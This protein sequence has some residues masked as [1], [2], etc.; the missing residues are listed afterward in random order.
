MRDQYRR[1]AFIVLLLGWAMYMAWRATTATWFVMTTSQGTVQLNVEQLAA[2]NVVPNPVGGQPATYSVFGTA[3][4]LGWLA[5]G[6]ILAGLAFVLRLSALAVL[7]IGASWMARTATIST[8]T[9]LIGVTGHGMFSLSGDHL[10][11]YLGWIWAVML[12]E[13]VLL[14]QL[15][16]ARYCEKK[17]ALSRGDTS[18][19]GVLDTIHTIQAGALNRFSR[20]QQAPRQ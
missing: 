9:M 17:A 15:T 18:V 10:T 8:H 19:G 6:A 3:A 14:I 7:A 13:L 20:D 11:S 5:I 4:P 1:A 16:Y 2:M 12:L